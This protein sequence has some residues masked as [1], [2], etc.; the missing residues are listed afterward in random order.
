MIYTSG[1]TGKPKGVGIRQKSVNNFIQGITNE[2]QIDE[3]NIMLSVTTCSFDIFGLETL[4]PL[5]KGIKIVIAKEDE[6]RDPGALNKLIISSDV[7]TIQTTPSRL[8]LMLKAKNSS[9]AFSKLKLI[10]VGGEGLPKTVL[11]D[12]QS[13][14]ASKIYNMYGP[15]ETTIWSSVK[16]LTREKEVTVGKPI[17][18]TQIYILDNYGGIVP[19]GVPGELCIAG[20]GVAVGY[21]NKE[22]LTAEKFVS[23]PF[24]NETKMYKTGDLA[25]WN[26]KGEVIVLGRLDNQVKIGGYRIEL[27]EIRKSFK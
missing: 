7:N 2:I 4:L 13:I 18:N 9:E 17:A 1:S 10:M 8:K 6:Q 21:L 16:D 5:T 27:G 3:R 26:E 19:V 24:I 25:K 11:S 12:I 20:D 14:T 23:N 15:T 22:E